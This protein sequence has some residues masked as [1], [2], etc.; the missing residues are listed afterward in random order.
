MNGVQTQAVGPQN[1]TVACVEKTFTLGGIKEPRVTTDNI[2][3]IQDNSPLFTLRNPTQALET[4]IHE[5]THMQ[6]ATITTDYIN[7]RDESVLG[8]R[9]TAARMVGSVDGGKN[10]GMHYATPQEAHANFVATN[11]VEELKKARVLK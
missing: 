9:L 4:I 7:G 5:P 10:Y 2:I 1:G 6:Q 8:A 11:V 3:Y